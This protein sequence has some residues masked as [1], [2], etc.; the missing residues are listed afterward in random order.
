MELAEAEGGKQ[1]AVALRVTLSGEPEP[2]AHSKTFE[3]RWAVC[4]A[5]HFL[6]A[7]LGHSRERCLGDIRHRHG[8][9]K[10]PIELVLLKWFRRLS[11]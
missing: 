4:A 8:T 6:R 9:L 11:Q 3:M 5:Q 1:A 7:G 10:F 2:Y